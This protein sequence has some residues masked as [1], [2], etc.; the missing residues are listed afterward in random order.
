MKYKYDKTKSNEWVYPVRKD[1]KM[2][3]CDCGLV[4]SFDFQIRNGQIRIRARRD[5]VQ[6]E[7]LR[8]KRNKNKL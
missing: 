4:H 3:C 5:D 6:T 7:Q 1:F 8:K 2:A